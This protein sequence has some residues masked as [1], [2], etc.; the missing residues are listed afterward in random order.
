M[1]LHDTNE[2]P[3]FIC[4]GF[5]MHSLRVNVGGSYRGR[6][7][8]GWWRGYRQ[9]PTASPGRWRLHWLC[10]MKLSGALK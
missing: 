3:F 4:N 9:A 6:T 7:G 2:S 1:K 5:Q 10:V 8:L